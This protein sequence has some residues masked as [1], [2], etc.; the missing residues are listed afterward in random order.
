MKNFCIEFKR[1]RQPAKLGWT[2]EERAVPQSVEIDL[3]VALA[4]AEGVSQDQTDATLDYR[5]IVNAIKRLCAEQEWKM[6]EKMCLDVAWEIKSLSTQVH[7]V[8]VSIS[9]S[10]FSEV[11]RLSVSYLL[12]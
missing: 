3:A 6:L 1:L 11:E 10:V 5:L 12:K 7:S 9:K 2:S 8:Q 4:V